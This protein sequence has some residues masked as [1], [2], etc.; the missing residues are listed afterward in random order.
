MQ[1]VLIPTAGLNAPCSTGSLQLLS[2]ATTAAP[3]HRRPSC[4]RGNNLEP[5]QISPCA[6]NGIS[7]AEMAKSQQKKSKEAHVREGGIRAIEVGRVS[8]VN[9]RRIPLLSVVDWNHGLASHLNQTD[10]LR[11]KQWAKC[12]S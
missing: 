9:L 5:N 3:V 10:R 7:I 6:G 1:L 8:S 12:L 11:M 2:D 4:W